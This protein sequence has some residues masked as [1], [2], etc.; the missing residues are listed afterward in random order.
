MRTLIGSSH[1]HTNRGPPPWKDSLNPG[2][3]RWKDWLDP[4]LFREEDESIY[5][6]FLAVRAKKMMGVQLKKKNP[7]FSSWGEEDEPYLNS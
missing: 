7:N 2:P 3:S 4:S 5:P 6:A 1:L